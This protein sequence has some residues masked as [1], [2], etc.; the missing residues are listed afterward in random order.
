MRV[1]QVSGDSM[2]PTLID[3]DLVLFDTAKTEPLDGKIM[4]VGIDNLLYIKRLR[5]SPEGYFLV[6]DN[7]G[8]CEPWRINPDTARFLGLVIWR[9]GAL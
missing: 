1:A 5:V 2:S 9:C 6:S 8:V 4:A 3:G 7:R